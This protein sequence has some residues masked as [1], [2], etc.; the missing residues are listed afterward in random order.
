MFQKLIFTSLV[1]LTIGCQTIPRAPK[2]LDEKA[3]AFSAPKENANIYIYR[4]EMFG[5]ANTI[6][7][8]LNGIVIG[9]TQAKTFILKNVPS[10]KQ[11]I[12]S[13]AETDDE[14]AFNVESG[15]NYFVWQEVK[16]GLFY[17]RSKLHIVS[18][19]KGQK[20]VREC[21]LLQ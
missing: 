20:E 10:G 2:E 12:V 9:K 18:E 19:E 5:G 8:L 14:I 3:K 16:M 7:V 4:H 21:S 11:N 17:A 15:K 6:P 13:Q 1:I